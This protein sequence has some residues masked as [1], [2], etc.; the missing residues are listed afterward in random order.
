MPNQP[1]ADPGQALIGALI[2]ADDRARRA[3]GMVL[4]RFYDFDEANQ[5]YV[6]R[7]RV[8]LHNMKHT[9]EEA[10]R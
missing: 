6:P 1:T 3:I 2:I 10:L 9:I 5:C 4:D 8:S 7:G